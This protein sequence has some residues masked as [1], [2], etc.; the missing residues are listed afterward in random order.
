MGKEKNKKQD[1]PVA[2]GKAENGKSA[3]SA[4]SGGSSSAL[5]V[6]I[7]IL[8]V[9]VGVAV[10]LKVQPPAGNDDATSKQRSSSDRPS[11]DDDVSTQQKKRESERSNVKSDASRSVDGS[12]SWSPKTLS[13]VLPCAGEGEYAKKTVESVA[14]SVPGGI[15]GGILEEIIVV[16]DGS[17]PPLSKKYLGDK[18][19]KSS[20]SS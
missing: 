10:F 3:G 2:S 11:K 13:V 12:L 5:V 9:A 20:L 19:Q 8:I 14:K 17:S 16:D 1:K 18:F 6:A 4:S 15:G 7:L